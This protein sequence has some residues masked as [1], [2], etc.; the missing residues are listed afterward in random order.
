MV[1]VS[2]QTRICGTFYNPETQQIQEYKYCGVFFDGWKDKLCQ[3]WEAKASMISFSGP[4]GEKR[5]GGQ[6]ILV[7]LNKLADI[8]QLQ[9]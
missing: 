8:R 2:Y 6:V 7:R 9:P 3:F 1:T 5:N 4:M